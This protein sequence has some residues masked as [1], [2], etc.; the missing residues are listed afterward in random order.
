MTRTFESRKNTHSFF[1]K[2][3]NEH[4]I[5]IVC[6]W[7]GGGFKCHGRVLDKITR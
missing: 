4:T 3:N 5:R 2:L 7:G 6:V 1:F